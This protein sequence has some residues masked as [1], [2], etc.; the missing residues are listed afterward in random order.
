[1]ATDLAKIGALA[2]VAHVA[3]RET[4][5]AQ[6]NGSDADFELACE[7]EH[8]AK[9]ALA[10]AIAALPADDFERADMRSINSTPPAR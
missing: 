10:D 5:N 3:S 7:K 9:S 8:K 6:R 2:V 4:T 1:M